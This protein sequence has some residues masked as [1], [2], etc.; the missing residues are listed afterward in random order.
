MLQRLR[1]LLSWPNVLAVMQVLFSVVVIRVVSTNVERADVS[2]YIEKSFTGMKMCHGQY[3]DPGTAG[4]RIVAVSTGFI[5]RYRSGEGTP[6]LRLKYKSRLIALW[7]SRRNCFLVLISNKET[8]VV[9][10]AAKMNLSA[11]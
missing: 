4:P 11:R 2:K 7:Q 8:H 5:V 1:C 9:E 6:S 3:F 10:I